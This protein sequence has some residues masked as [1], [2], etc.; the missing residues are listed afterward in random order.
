MIET[1]KVFNRNKFYDKRGSLSE[2]FKQSEFE[3]LLKIKVN[4]VQDNFVESH[5]NVLRGL[6]YQAEPKTQGKYISV[7]KGEIFDVIVDIRKNSNYYGKWYGFNLSS[8]NG[9]SLWVPSGFAHGFLTLSEKSIVL[10]KLTNFYSKMHDRSIRWDSKDLNIIWPIS[11][12]MILSDK[13]KEAKEFN[14]NIFL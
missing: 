9:K 1:F 12:G 11:S 8:L 2:T 10:Y 5:K 6:H 14:R 7:L 13:D 3:K 4:F